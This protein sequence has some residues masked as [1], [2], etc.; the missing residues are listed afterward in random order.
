MSWI[1]WVV[2]GLLAGWL[3]SRLTGARRGLITNLAIGL[4]GSMLGGWIVAGLGVPYDS[5]RFWPA[6][7]VSILGSL[8]LLAILN[9]LFSER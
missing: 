2:I 8:L 9:L 1:V 4:I 7:G 3:A 6:L 5:E